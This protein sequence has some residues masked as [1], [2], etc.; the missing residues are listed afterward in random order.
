MID[1]KTCDLCIHCEM[2]AWIDKFKMDGC[3]FFDNGKEI[4][5]IKEHEEEQARISEEQMEKN[6]QRIFGTEKQTDDEIRVTVGDEVRGEFEKERGVVIECRDQTDFVILCIDGVARHSNI[7]D[8]TKTG[9]HFDA[10]E[11]ILEQMQEDKE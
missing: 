9:R 1:N 8:F 3:E 10:I 11:E 5:R 7:N 4:S 6:I 2:C